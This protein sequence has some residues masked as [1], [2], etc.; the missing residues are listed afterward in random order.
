MTPE[1]EALWPQLAAL[2]E[3]YMQGMPTCLLCKQMPATTPLV[4][5]VAGT[6]DGRVQ[7][8]VVAVCT[9]CLCQDDVEARVTTALRQDQA[10]RTAALWN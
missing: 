10:Q 5:L 3:R 2:A 9:F 6:S 8:C 1:H 4:S 7:G